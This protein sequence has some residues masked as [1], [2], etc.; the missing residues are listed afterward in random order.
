MKKIYSIL[1]L[2]FCCLHIFSLAQEQQVRIKTQGTEKTINLESGQAMMVGRGDSIYFIKTNDPSEITRII[3]QFDIPP[4][5][6]EKTI[7]AGNK[8]VNWRDLH[9]TSI[10]NQ[11][12]RFKNDLIRL[13]AENADFAKNESFE[14]HV[15]I[16]Y[17][18]TEVFNGISLTTP[19]WHAK[20]IEKLPYVLKVHEDVVVHTSLDQSVPVIGADQIWQQYNITGQGITVGILDTGIDYL[21]PDLGG[22][23]GPGFKVT[24]GYDFVNDDN[25]PMDDHSHG[26]HVAGIVAA[27]GVLQGVAPGASLRGYKVL[28]AEGWGHGSWI[29]AGIEQSVIDGVHVLNASLGGPGSPDDPMAQAMDNA[30][31]A[32]VVCVV[33]AGNSG[34]N[35]YTIDS[36]GV[37]KKALTV[38]ATFVFDEIAGFSS[39]G[40]VEGSYDVK[41]DVLAPG[42]Y[43]NSTIPGNGY[44]QY[45]GTSMAAPHVAGAVALFLNQYPDFSPDQVKSVFMQSAVDLSYDVWTQGKGRIDLPEAFQIP[46]FLAEPGIFS[47]G[48]VDVSCDIWTK[49]DTLWITNTQTEDLQAT[50]TLVETLPAGITLTIT[51]TTIS[52][53][54]NSTTPVIVSVE[55]D[56]T[57][58]PYPQ[59]Q[60]PYFGFSIEINTANYATNVPVVFVKSPVIHI[61]LDEEPLWVLAFEHDGFIGSGFV[62]NKGAD[63]TIPMPAGTYD[64]FVRF[65]DDITTLIY[66]GEVLE[67]VLHIVASK[68]DA[69]NYITIETPD[70]YGDPINVKV[71]TDF[72]NLTASGWWI[73]SFYNSFVTERNF[74]S[75]STVEWLF[76]GMSE[77]ESRDTFYIVG[78]KMFGCNQSQLIS[79]QPDELIGLQLKTSGYDAGSALFP[80]MWYEIISAGATFWDTNSLP[81]THPYSLDMM[82]SPHFLDNNHRMNFQLE[83][84]KYEGSSFEPSL[85]PEYVSPRIAQTSTHQFDFFSYDHPPFGYRPVNNIPSRGKLLDLNMGPPVWNG[86]FEHQVGD[87]ILFINLS[88][89]FQ[90]QKKGMYKPNKLPYKVFRD[91]DLVEEGDFYES[92]PVF[93]YWNASWN[94]EPGSYII[95]MNQEQYKVQGQ[96]GQATARS[97]FHTGQEYGYVPRLSSF[98]IYYQDAYYTDLV[99]IGEDGIIEFTADI[100]PDYLQEST[101]NLEY[102]IAPG[103]QW[104]PLDYQQNQQSYVALIPDTIPEGYVSLR[105]YAEDASGSFLEYTAEPAFLMA[106]V[107]PAIV[108]INQANVNIYQN[109]AIIQATVFSDGGGAVRARGVVWG[110]TPEPTLDNCVGFTDEGFGLGQFQS[111]I[112]DLLPLNTYYAKAYATNGFGTSYSDV[113]LLDQIPSCLP[114]IALYATNTTQTSATVGWTEPGDAQLWDILYGPLGFEPSSGVTLVTDINQP[115]Y[116]LQ[117]LNHSTHY[118]FYVRSQCGIELSPWSAPQQFWTECMGEAFTFLTPTPGHVIDLGLS[119]F[120]EFSYAFVGCADFGINIDLYDEFQNHLTWLRSD[121]ITESVV[122]EHDLELPMAMCSGNYQIRLS[123]WTDNNLTYN[124]LYSP[125]FTVNNNTDNLHIAQ[126]NWWMVALTGQDI[127]IRWN[128]SNSDDVSLFYSLDNGQ[129]W[130]PIVENTP[131]GCGFYGWGF[132]NYNWVVPTSIAGTYDESLIKVERADNPGISSVSHP[133]R[134]T[135]VRPIEIISPQQGDIY[136]VGGN[137]DLIFNSAEH[138][139]IDIHFTDQFGGW[140]HLE[141]FEATVGTHSRTYTTANLAE[142]FDLMFKIQ[143]N[144]TGLYFDSPFFAIL[145]DVPICKEPTNVQANHITYNSAEISWIIYGN[146]SSWNLEWGVNYFEPGAGKLITGIDTNPYTLGG[147]PQGRVIYFYLQSDCGE[148]I[149]SDWAG[150]FSFDTG[151]GNIDVPFFENFDAFSLWQVPACWASWGDGYTRVVDYKAYSNPHSVH[152]QSTAFDLSMLITPEINANLSNLKVKF[153]AIPDDSPLQKIVEVGTVSTQNQG[154]L[155]TPV[156]QFELNG[157]PGH[158]WQSVAVSFADYAGND[159]HIA[160]RFSNTHDEWQ[161]FLIDD[162]QIEY[163]PAC[164]APYN[165]LAN[166]ITLNS[167]LL[168]WQHSGA[169]APYDLIYGPY[170]F[171]PFSEGTLVEGLLLPEYEATG[172]NHSTFYEFYVLGDCNGIA[173]EWSSAGLFR[174]DCGQA[175]LT[176]V[177]PSGGEV[178]NTDQ[179]TE[180]PVQID[181]IGCESSDVQVMIVDEYLN[182]VSSGNWFHIHATGTYS[183]NIQIPDAICSGSYAIGMSY[184]DETT[185]NN[186]SHYSAF[187]DIVNDENKLEVSQPWHNQTLLTGRNYNIRWNS[188]MNEPV[189]LYYSLDN[190][191]NWHAIMQNVASNCGTTPWGYNNYDWLVP[192]TIQGTYNECRIKISSLDNPHVYAISETF[193]ITSIQPL[194]FIQPAAGDIVASGSDLDLVF[195]VTEP[196]G[197]NIYLVQSNGGSQHLGYYEASAGVNAITYNTTGWPEGLDQ[198]FHIFHFKS[199][200]WFQSPRFAILDGEPGC[201]PPGYA[202][203]SDQEPTSV[204][205]SWVDYGGSNSWD[206]EWGIGAINQGEGNL[207]SN[208]SQN[209]TSLTSLTPGSSFTFYLASNCDDGL[210]S[211]WV[212]P[213]WFYTPL[214][215]TITAFTGENGNVSPLGQIN[216]LPGA[217]Q[218]FVIEPDFGYEVADV[219]ID[220]VSVGAVETFTFSNV[221]ANHTIE[222]IFSPLTNI[223]HLAKEEDETITGEA[224]F[225]SPY[226]IWVAGF[227]Y[228]FIVE[229]G[230]DVTLVAAESIR[231]LPGTKVAS[232][233]QLH[234]HIA[235]DGV[236]YCVPSGDAE[237]DDPLPAHQGTDSDGD[238]L[239]LDR[240]NEFFRM[241][242]NPTEGTFTLELTGTEHD[243]IISVDIFGMT[244]SRVFSVNLPAQR[245][246]ML[247]LEGQQPGMYFIRVM[248][249]QQI[250]IERLIKR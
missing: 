204:D 212:G 165:L 173:S 70:I 186:V 10:R 97:G 183:L 45:S 241:Y 96:P 50:I 105:I 237:K 29:V 71:P 16:G 120:L 32:G 235:V 14:D 111:I 127:D 76:G 205:I 134:I 12:E 201:L 225:F 178:F 91:G 93:G 207:I 80:I 122:I 213:F 95:E 245:M 44:A 40:P 136:L 220:G 87:Q 118:D 125:L 35:Y 36:P 137:I 177:S 129:N 22:G 72:Y 57:I 119:N 77:T 139:W 82:I 172:L 223:L 143:H 138:S 101:I 15:T 81:L 26:T 21:H 248:S 160:I 68:M 2:V 4:V 184:W 150:P 198:F 103:T 145:T 250:G 159:K 28:H 123:Y 185:N 107:T 83:F 168:S 217:D 193:I 109:K 54:P 75:F 113:W 78:G 247:S 219:L 216:V 7:N 114:P 46:P 25:D 51:P 56:N 99:G 199:Q 89:V 231:L 214:H 224:C 131:T 48:L 162:F 163:L 11:H 141:T 13:F 60:P 94:L 146:V 230:G 24:G 182:A 49:T 206:L 128:S 240:N 227:G 59:E 124:E 203:V 188:S 208:I 246:H 67:E 102:S 181:F 148:G 171:D 33:A 155:F 6:V 8:S 86:I 126:P 170:G 20:A 17:S 200:M 30:T 239:T 234:S 62:E 117:G 164:H 79:Y 232:G 157:I 130:D 74:N 147:L 115:D 238:I 179:T 55:V 169:S 228:D 191:I 133:F 233:A 3:V 161:S 144:N 197:M 9:Q 116:L 176:I 210:Q 189:N 226:S 88:N 23:I 53:P 63:F 104:L 242:P 27:N 215:Y 149:V 61:S 64:I 249:G 221:T 154:D 174:T 90:F 52:M 106:E 112:P 202:Q 190:G 121:N 152:F 244:G 194:T 34:S 209:H 31:L 236:D 58:V 18:Y 65:K 43:T 38:G 243:E 1:V 135:S 69:V 156:G 195:S 98:N 110:N 84:Y 166:D 108:A 229:P 39:R 158:P 73:V 175:S 85:P 66:E 19:G 167:A 37:A 218:P 153:K 196:S 92:H 100:H 222:A 41:P 187:F 211:D 132:N 192:A 140:I 142:G 47:M 42:V 151:C 180:I 5:V